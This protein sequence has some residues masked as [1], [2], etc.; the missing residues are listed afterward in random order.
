[1]HCCKYEAKVNGRL[2]FLVDGRTAARRS[3]GRTGDFG[4][5]GGLGRTGG[6]GGTDVERY[7]VSRGG[8]ASSAS[9][10]GPGGTD[11]ARRPAS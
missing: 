5:T 11:V 4:R 10:G 1:M 8:P 2:T 7:L 3:A 9:R 6:P